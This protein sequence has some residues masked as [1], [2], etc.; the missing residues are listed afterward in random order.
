MPLAEDPR[1]ALS[2]RP[3]R[4][5]GGESLER[6]RLGIDLT[7][8]GAGRDTQDTLVAQRDEAARAGQR[9][10]WAERETHKFPG[11][12]DGA[13]E[14]CL[15][16]RLS[17]SDQD[18]LARKPLRQRD[19]WRA[20]HV[21]QP[22]KLV[23]IPGEHRDVGVTAL[24]QR[25][26]GSLRTSAN[27]G[28]RAYAAR[29]PVNLRP[30][31]GL[32]DAHVGDGNGRLAGKLL[33]RTDLDV[34]FVVHELSA[35]A[36]ERIGDVAVKDSKAKCFGRNDRSKPAVPSVE[37]TSV[38]LHRPVSPGPLTRQC[39]FLAARK[40]TGSVVLPSDSTPVSV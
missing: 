28:V 12:G 31:T 6:M 37:W 23:A 30:A 7:T 39:P 8:S 25:T 21:G 36:C 32:A 5:R 17:A 4:G 2:N 40:R 19:A 3:R 14:C 34:R 20:G 16:A 18:N 9:P 26:R 29:D 27:V 22:K 10:G 35:R 15:A 13:L 33:D 11:L 1:D 38:W 24:T